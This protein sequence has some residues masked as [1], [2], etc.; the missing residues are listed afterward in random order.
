METRTLLDG[1]V[2]PAIGFGTYS[3][4]GE[5]GA[6]QIATALGLG[7]RLLDTALGY[8]NAHA[9]RKPLRLSGLDRDEVLVTSK[10]PQPDHGY[11]RTKRPLE[12]SLANLRLHHIDL[13]LIHWPAPEQ[14]L[15]VETWQAMIDLRDEGKTTSIGVSNFSEE[16]LGRLIRE[17]GVTPKVN[18]VPL[19]PGMPQDELLAVHA[20]LGV[21][22]ESYSPLKHGDRLRSDPTLQGIATAHRATVNQVALRW[23]VQLGAL[24][25]PRSREAA[26]QK[27]NLDVF[28]FELSDDEMGRITALRW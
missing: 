27:E 28:G 2:L 21:L 3:L 16:Q 9:V 14:D 15:Y 18:Q 22:T 23:N 6:Q 13:Y 8:H 11:E 20:R 1:H 17:T 4:D 19:S 5:A 25:I 24:P 7:Y 10:V 26:H 12:T